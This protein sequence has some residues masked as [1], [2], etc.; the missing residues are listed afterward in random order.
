[1]AVALAD[2]L[3]SALHA[4]DGALLTLTEAAVETGY[5]ADHLGWLVRNGRIP[6]HGRPN[7]PR[8]RRIDLP[9][10]SKLLPSDLTAGRP[11][12]ISKAQIARALIDP[13]HEETR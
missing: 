5:S 9:R 3:E 1:M 7:A 11:L 12:T 2:E 10:K 8:V 13:R 6:N 4:T